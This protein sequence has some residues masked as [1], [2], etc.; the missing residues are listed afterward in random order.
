MINWQQ[1]DTVLLDMDGTLLDLHFDNHFWNE[2]LPKRYAEVHGKNWSDVKT[3]LMAEYQAMQGSLNWYCL[4]YWSE[5]LDLDIMALKREVEHLIAIRP[6]VENFL[7]C[8]K[9]SA[10]QSWLVTNAHRSGVKL[11][12]NKTGIHQYFDQVVSSHDF[13]VAKENDAFWQA[14]HATHPFDPERSLLIDDNEQ[15]LASAQRFGI[16]HLITL[17][18]PDSQQ[19]PRHL[20]SFPSIHHFDEIMPTLDYGEH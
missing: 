13:N 19:Q 12:F 3:K 5:Y 11:K 4:D 10:Q 6:H 8:L 7:Q 9:Q 14:L 20:T 18:Q 2:H 1:I 16:A 17:K 15:V